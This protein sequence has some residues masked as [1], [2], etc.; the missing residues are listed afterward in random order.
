MITIVLIMRTLIK[1]SYRK[2]LET[3]YENN[4]SP[5]HLRRI[6]REIEKRKIHSIPV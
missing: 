5:L 3:F 4:N 6:I 2:I 1:D